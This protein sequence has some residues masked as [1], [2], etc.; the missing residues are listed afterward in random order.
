MKAS[1]GFSAFSNT[2]LQK[3]YACFILYSKFKTVAHVYLERVIT[4]LFLVVI[5]TEMVY[6]FFI[7]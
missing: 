6:L 5:V 4:F 7:V 3:K 2:T 1:Y